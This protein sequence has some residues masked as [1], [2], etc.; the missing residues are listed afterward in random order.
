[1]AAIQEYTFATFEDEISTIRNQGRRF[2]VVG[3]DGA[4]IYLGTIITDSLQPGHDAI[5]IDDDEEEGHDYFTF[6]NGIHNGVTYPQVTLRIKNNTLCVKFVNAD[7]EV[8]TRIDNLPDR[9]ISKPLPQTGGKSRR[10]RCRKTKNKRRK[11]NRRY[12]Y[13]YRK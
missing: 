5:D 3:D 8:V 13:S 12:R 2:Y 6:E 10:K 9:I 11:S 7:Y 1:M 4:E